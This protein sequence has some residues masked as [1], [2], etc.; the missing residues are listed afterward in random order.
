[1]SS[2]KLDGTA[3]LRRLAHRRLSPASLSP[4]WMAA[5]KERE[6]RTH[7]VP[8]IHSSIHSSIHPSIEPSHTTLEMMLI[9]LMMTRARLRFCLPLARPPLFFCLGF[10]NTATHTEPGRQAG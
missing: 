10:L 1:M 4:M 2:W 3:A 7:P 6:T 5:A 8:S 9:V